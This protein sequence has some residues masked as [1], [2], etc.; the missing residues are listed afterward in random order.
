MARGPTVPRRCGKLKTPTMIVAATTAMRMPGM[1]LLRLSSED[2]GER[3]AADRHRDPIDLSAE[4]AL[5]DRPDIVQ[6]AVGSRS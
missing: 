4:N 2:H 6:R 3:A 1:R 5:A